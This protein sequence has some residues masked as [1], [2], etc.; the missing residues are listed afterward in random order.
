[1]HFKYFDPVWNTQP[2]YVILPILMEHDAMFDWK[3]FL[4]LAARH[5]PNTGR[6]RALHDGILPP[7]GALQFRQR[8]FCAFT[9]FSSLETV[10]NYWR[11]EL[12]DEDDLGDSSTHDGGRNWTQPFRFPH[13][14]TELV[15]EVKL[16]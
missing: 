1:M 9:T 10:C 2:A 11:T 13:R 16:Y 6:F 3:R 7:D 12:P 4:T 8:S 5:M 15:L 14:I